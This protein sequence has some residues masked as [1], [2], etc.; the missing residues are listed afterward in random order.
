MITQAR[1]A[2]E[3]GRLKG[4][5]N[6]LAESMLLV[7][8]LSD[9]HARFSRDSGFIQAIARIIYPQQESEDEHGEDMTSD[10]WFKTL[11]E[12]KARMRNDERDN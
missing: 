3:R 7:Y 5:L 10:E 9:E 11:D 2:Y 4:D 12:M 1:L 6:P 8:L